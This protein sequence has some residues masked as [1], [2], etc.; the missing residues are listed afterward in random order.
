M[1]QFTLKD[2]KTIFEIILLGVLI[3][4]NLKSMFNNPNKKTGANYNKLLPQI[5]KT[6]SITT[7]R[8]SINFL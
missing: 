6:L 7:K 8:P 4:K 1:Y 2:I 5:K 3:A